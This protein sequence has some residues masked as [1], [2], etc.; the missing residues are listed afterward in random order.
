LETVAGERVKSEPE[1]PKVND[2]VL[3]RAIDLLKGLAVVR[4]WKS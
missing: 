2:P 1:K 4:Q 3:L